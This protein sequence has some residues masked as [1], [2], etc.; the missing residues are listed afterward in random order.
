[1]K[2]KRSGI[3]TK[4]LLLAIII[5][6]ATSLI[7][8]SGKIREAS[9]KIKEMEE[10]TA[11]IRIENDKLKGAIDNSTSDAVIESIARGELGLTY[12]GERVFSGE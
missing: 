3:L 1:M 11:Q 12:P 5:Y 7:T 4:L 10:K 9:D 8:M 2:K 6:A